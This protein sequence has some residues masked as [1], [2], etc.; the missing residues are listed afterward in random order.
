MDQPIIPRRRPTNS[1]F[2]DLKT[3]LSKYFYHWPLFILGLVVAFAAAFIYLQVTSPVYPINA[4][5]LV[6]DEKKSPQEKSSM[7]ELNLT[8]SPRSAETEIQVLTST[9][10]ISH[11]VNDL[12]LS[13]T[14]TTERFFF[15]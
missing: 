14:Y 10:L 12:G 9:K 3:V 2:T 13:T 6:K 7:E 15:Q 8:S 4:T 1:Q 11:V 5:I